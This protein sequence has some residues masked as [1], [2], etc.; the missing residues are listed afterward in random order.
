MCI[1][2]TPCAYL[3]ILHTKVL[4]DIT[5][6]VPYVGIDIFQVREELQFRHVI[7]AVWRSGL[8]NGEAEYSDEHG[9]NLTKCEGTSMDLPPGTCEGAP[10]KIMYEL[11]WHGQGIGE[12]NGDGRRSRCGILAVPMCRVSSCNCLGAFRHM[13]Y[14]LDCT[15][16]HART[17]QWTLQANKQGIRG[18]SSLE[19]T[20]DRDI[21]TISTSLVTLQ[22][23]F[24]PSDY[25]VI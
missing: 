8:I 5:K 18:S 19:W 12:L 9:H 3:Q 11:D 21:A 20:L 2:L 4:Y 16:H 17:G 24:I 23:F 22:F 15:Q 25:Y 1:Y 13:Y 7:V 10:V 6:P 14:H